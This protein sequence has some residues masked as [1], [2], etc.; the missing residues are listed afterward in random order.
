MSTDDS[1]SK[2]TDAYRKGYELGFS[3][4]G[5]SVGMSADDVAMSK[6]AAAVVREDKEAQEAICKVAKFILSFDDNSAYEQ[7]IYSTIEKSAG[8]VSGVVFDTYLAPV[9]EAVAEADAKNT[10][11]KLA[12]A[13]GAGPLKLYSAAA[14]LGSD[15]FK[16]IL[17]ASALLG[18]TGG[19][20]WWAVNRGPS[21]DD[22]ETQA[23]QDQAHYYRRVAKDIKRKLAQQEAS[24]QKIVDTKK[25]ISGNDYVL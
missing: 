25:A 22:I 14:S 10:L 12:K 4:A 6:A 17:A 1:I 19:A 13:N 8:A 15:A 3:M 20:A 16:T 9:L 5:V 11:I 23:K 18:A 2:F 24:N 21:E 7:A